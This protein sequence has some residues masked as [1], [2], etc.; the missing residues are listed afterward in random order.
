MKNYK[1]DKWIA[2]KQVEETKFLAEKTV[3]LLEYFKEDLYKLAENACY[4]DFL[5]LCS[6]L[7]DNSLELAIDAIAARAKFKFIGDNFDELSEPATTDDI[8]D[9]RKT[10]GSCAVHVID[11]EEALEDFF[12][13]H[14]GSK[15]HIVEVFE[16]AIKKMKEKK[17]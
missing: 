7:R 14:K 17:D 9:M 13:K 8:E 3:K 15:E 1:L 5:T 16:S 11:S 12:K 6:K 4:K 2:E 10:F